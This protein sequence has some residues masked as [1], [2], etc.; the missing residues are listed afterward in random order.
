M[1]FD[2]VIGN[3]PYQEEKQDGNETY[4]PPVYDKFLEAAYKVSDKVEMIHPA[5]FLFKAGRTPKAW[6][7][8][9]LADKH[10]RIIRYEPDATKVFANTEIKGGVVVSYRDTTKDYGAIGIFTQYECLNSILKKIPNDSEK[11]TETIF[12]QNRFNLPMLYEDHPDYKSSIGSDGKDSRLEK[13]IFEKIPVFS[14]EKRNDDDIK[15]TG[16]YNGK[17]TKRYIAK[18]Y[19]DI[20]HNNLLKY[21]VIIPVANGNGEF[22]ATLGGIEVLSPNEAYT[23][24]FIGIGAVSTQFEVNSIL[25][26]LK[27]KFL[28]TMLSILKVTQ[29]TNKDVWNY[30]PLQDFTENSDIDWSKTI[31]EIDLQLYKKYGLTD[32]EI[33]FI[34]TH[35]KEMN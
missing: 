8:K 29:M 22:G 7:E 2:F 13:N 28:R 33:D 10:F 4:S 34:E 14:T 27:S 23:R 30:V 35:V 5:R 15:V 25:A 9:M 21:K 6:N 18:K 32:E 20:E 26:Y 11:I 17:R 19:I 31:H 12:I 3:P 1:K 24:S 16:I